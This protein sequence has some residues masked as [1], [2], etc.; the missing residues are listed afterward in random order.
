MAGSHTSPGGFTFYLFLFSAC[1]LLT[2]EQ[3]FSFYF[4]EKVTLFVGS[5][6]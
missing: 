2:Q 1:F 5:F 6:A 4:F 3:Q